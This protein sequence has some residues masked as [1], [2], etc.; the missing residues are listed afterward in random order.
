MIE[1]RLDEYLHRKVIAAWK[2][3]FS[4]SERCISALRDA[5]QL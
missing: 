5:F 3:Y 4:G 2:K 1:F